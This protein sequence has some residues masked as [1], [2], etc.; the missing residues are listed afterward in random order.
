MTSD[1]ELSLSDSSRFIAVRA[2]REETALLG[3]G[4]RRESFYLCSFVGRQFAVVK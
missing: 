3:L 2:I 4:P 1:A